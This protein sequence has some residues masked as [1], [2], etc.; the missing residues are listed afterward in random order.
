MPKNCEPSLSLPVLDRNDTQTADDATVSVVI[1]N[2]NGGE[3]I[4][5]CLRSLQAQDYPGPIE[6]IVVDN[7]STDGSPARILEAFPGIRMIRN[8]RNRG[9]A[10]A[11]NQGLRIATGRYCLPLNF[12]IVLTP[13]FLSEMVA[14]IGEDPAIGIVSGKLLRLDSRTASE[15]IID[16]TGIVMPF[17]F[18][19]ARGQEEAD[20]GQYDTPCEV[21]G[22]CGAAPL[23]RREMLTDIAIRGEFFDETFVTYV[24]D[25]DLSWRAQLRGW[26]CRYTPRAVAFHL[27]GATRRENPREQEVY[28]RIG[29]R[30]RYL[31]LVKNLLPGT[32]RE[33]WRLILWREFAFIDLCLRRHP[34]Y[35]IFQAILGA[36][37]RLPIALW[38]RR[39]IMRRVTV[40]RE[41]I[42][43]FFFEVGD[44]FGGG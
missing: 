41:R 42:E 1:V 34:P 4:D 44:P 35:L 13:S 20:R 36:L 5:G 25:V 18:P 9:F 39:L 23:Y 7:A 29:Y 28:Y 3:L 31:M 8:H 16:S 17:H 38:K 14:A 43:R 40:E 21:F 30:N 37:L 24:E 22:A 32:I 15:R 12:D 19:V 26:R 27:R 10:A 11:Q 33:H 6:T 2:W